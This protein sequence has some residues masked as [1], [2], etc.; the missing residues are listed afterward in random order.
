M[1][2]WI[3]VLVAMV[4]LWPLSRGFAI[5][6]ILSHL[7][8]TFA[9]PLWLVKLQQQKK[10]VEMHYNIVT[11]NMS[12]NSFL[13]QT[14]SLDEEGRNLSANTFRQQPCSRV[15]LLKVLKISRCFLF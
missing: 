8:V 5:T 15:P 13:L 12:V 11:D 2:T 1:M 3:L 6:F 7:A 4:I 14:M 9:C 10:Y